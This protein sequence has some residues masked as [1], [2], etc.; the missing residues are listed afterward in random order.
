MDTPSYRTDI[1]FSPA[2][3]RAQSERGSRDG[4]ARMAQRRDF[5]AII[6]EDLAAFI[7]E[8]DS[9]YLGTAS[10]SGRPYIQHRGGPKG[11]VKV[12]DENRLAFAD[13][14]GNRQYISLGNLS[15]NDQAFLFVM[16][17]G[18]RR[19]VKI[20]GRAGFVE[21]D[22]ELLARVTDPEYDAVPERVL[23]F[24]VEAWDRNCRQHITPRYTTDEFLSL[25]RS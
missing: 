22:A 23:V 17:Y 6:T 19:R 2:V 14:S 16:D 12:L 10:A 7:A 1:A 15:E 18:D 5:H 20:W 13:Y 21:D 24:Q 8:R 25:S 11:F 9:V 4:Y 3:K